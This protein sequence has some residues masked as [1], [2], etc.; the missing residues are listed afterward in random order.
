MS[1]SGKIAIVQYEIACNALA[2]EFSKMFYD[3]QKHYW[4]GECIGETLDIAGN[5][6]VMSDIVLCMKSGI[7]YDQLMEWY[8]NRIENEKYNINLRS[9]IM[10]LPKKK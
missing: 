9:F 4:V 10:N 5:F 6:F 3:G 8:N 2:N 1:T 7:T